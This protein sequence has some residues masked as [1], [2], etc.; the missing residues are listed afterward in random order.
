MN[1]CAHNVLDLL[2]HNLLLAD[3]G[4]VFKIVDSLHQVLI[5]YSQILRYLKYVLILDFILLQVYRNLDVSIY[6]DVHLIVALVELVDNVVLLFELV[7]QELAHVCQ[8]LS[9]YVLLFEELNV[10]YV[11]RNI[12]EVHCNAVLGRLFEQLNR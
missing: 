10:F 12:V 4:L 7:G 3:P 2:D 6:H 1:L 8:I 9:N 11:P 5:I